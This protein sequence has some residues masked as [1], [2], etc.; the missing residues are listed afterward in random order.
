MS[1]QTTLRG[2]VE[3]VTFRNE[4]NGY[5]V[6]SLNTDEELVTVVGCLPQIAAGDGLLL[7]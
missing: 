5:T 1:E 7:S 2:T 6:L 3:A 4:Q